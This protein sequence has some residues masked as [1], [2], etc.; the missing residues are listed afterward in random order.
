MS[1][2]VAVIGGGAAGMMAASAAAARGHQVTLFEKNEKLGKKVFI[3]GKGR[4]NVTNACE[5][6]DLFANII[7]NPKFL[8]SAIYGYDNQ[9]VCDFFEKA[10]CALKTERGD[11]VFPLSDHSSDVIRALEKDLQKKS[12]KICLQTRVKDILCDDLTGS[13]KGVE[14]YDGKKVQADCVIMATGGVSYASTGSDGEGLNIAKAHG[15]TVV[16]CVP[17]LVPFE[18]KEDWCHSLMGLSLKN[19]EG[20][21]I[22]DKKEVHSGFGEML[23]THFGISGPLVL[24][25]SSYYAAAMRKKKNKKKDV[26]VE[27]MYYIDLKPALSVQQLDKRILRDFEENINKQFKNAIDGLFP[28]K[29]IPVM[30]RLSGIDPEKK[31][32]EITKEERQS[33]AELIKNLPLTV[34]GTR[35]F[36]EAI[37]TQGGINVKEVNPSTMES[38][39]IKGLYFAGEML[40]VDALTGGFNLQIAWSTGHLAGECCE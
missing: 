26:P 21:L 30:I 11:R 20:R 10:G 15:H 2:K 13:V 18:T 14:L 27:T 19:V 4:C 9:A 5:I 36:K 33:F 38:K 1:I 40:D 3:T 8:Y 29:L 7:T 24:S 35:E 6:E 39:L 28:S 17:A 23:F 31:V 25:A 22:I 34:T 12:V 16:D 32:N 37:I